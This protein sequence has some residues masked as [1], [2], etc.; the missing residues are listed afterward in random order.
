MESRFPI[1]FQNLARFFAQI[2]MVLKGSRAH[3]QLPQ[4]SRSASL[5]IAKLLASTNQAGNPN[6][7]TC[8]VL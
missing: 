4:V 2:A 6:S 7:L 8:N 3:V 5:I 1:I